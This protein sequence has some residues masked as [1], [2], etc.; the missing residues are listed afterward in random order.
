G[1]NGLLGTN[2]SDGN[3]AG[4]TC[5]GD[6]KTSNGNCI[7]NIEET[8]TPEPQ[9]DDI[10]AVGADAVKANGKYLENGRI[11]I[12]RNGIKYGADGSVVK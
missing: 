9:P 2:T 8:E 12:Y 6:K 11:V 10:D 4:S 1:K 3:A 5:Y 7:W